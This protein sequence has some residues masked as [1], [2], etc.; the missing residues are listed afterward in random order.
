MREALDLNDE[1]IQP[2]LPLIDWTL[3]LGLASTPHLFLFLDADLDPERLVVLEREP[4]R[5][6]RREPRRLLD[7]ALRGT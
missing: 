4:E 2:F 7:D 5:L 1:E 3:W 6:R